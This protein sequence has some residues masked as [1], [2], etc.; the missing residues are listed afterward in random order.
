MTDAAPT[1]DEVDRICG[2]KVRHGSMGAAA[3]AVQELERS[4][5]GET[6]TAYACPF[7]PDG[8][9]HFHVD[10]APSLEALEDLARMMRGLPAAAPHDQPARARRRRSRKD[11][12]TR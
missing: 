1:S 5:P 6:W 3:H 10:G 8:A 2:T 9:P 12:S 11:R 7:A 4:R